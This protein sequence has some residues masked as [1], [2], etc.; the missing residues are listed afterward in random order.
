[1]FLVHPHR[2]HYYYG[3]TLTLMM[4]IRFHT[5]GGKG[6]ARFMLDFCYAVN[7][8]TVINAVFYPDNRMLW[9]AN[10]GMSNV[11]LLAVVIWRNSLVFHSLDKVT[12]L[13]I[14]FM[15]PL[16][17]YN[18]RWSAGTPMCPPDA[19]GNRVDHCSLDFF[20][21]YILPLQFYA[22]WQLLYWFKTELVDRALL[23]SDKNIQTSLRWFVRDPRNPLVRAV[24][25]KCIAWGLMPA[26]EP[27]DPDKLVTKLVYAAS[28]LVVTLIAVAPTCLN[29]QY[30]NLNAA[31]VL[32]AFASVTYNGSNFYFENFA[33]RYQKKLQARA[34]EIASADDGVLRGEGHS[35]S[36][37]AANVVGGGGESSGS[38]SSSA[39]SCAG[40]EGGAVMEGE[41]ESSRM[42][43]ET[44]KKTE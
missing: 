35:V 40:E 43:A 16:V 6:W 34:A 32:L 30:V 4:A 10:Y 25:K 44:A 12:S 38:G 36:N 37:G 13:F 8:S 15:P 17:C 41:D 20:D 21:G 42:S 24:H 5:Y 23:V 33:V 14:H 39:G 2:F 7:L 3:T 19:E 26:G 28:Q 1:V 31:W 22:M 9:V 29:F 18:A 11:L 27:M